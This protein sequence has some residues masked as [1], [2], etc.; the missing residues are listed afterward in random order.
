[1]W[2]LL[3][4]LINILKFLFVWNHLSFSIFLKLNEEYITFFS[5]SVDLLHYALF[6]QLLH[7]IP[8]AKIFV[9]FM[10]ENW[11]FYDFMIVFFMLENW[12]FLRKSNEK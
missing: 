7:N 9:L 2:I 5:S 6:K 8:S 11:W 12:W 1:M 3:L 4:F 10:I